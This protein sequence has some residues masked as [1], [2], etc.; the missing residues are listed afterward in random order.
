MNQPVTPYE[1]ESCSAEDL[2]C[3][4]EAQ[5]RLADVLA[6]TW[7]T[8]EEFEECDKWYRAVAE[9]GHAEAQYQVG[10][11][12]YWGHGVEEDREEA[13]RWIRKAAEQ[14]DSDAREF[15]EEEFPEKRDDGG[16]GAK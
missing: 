1:D 15:L 9:Q 3:D 14:G 7:E 10:L 13:F 12:Y 5:Y 16:E 2:L 11:G 8:Q 6:E 4:P